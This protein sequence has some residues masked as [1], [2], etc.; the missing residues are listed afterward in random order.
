MMF[1][2]SSS[3][4]KRRRGF[5]LVL[6]LSFVV[7]LTVVVL[8]FLSN[9]LLQRTVAD[10]SANQTRADLFAKG[11]IDTIVGDLKQ[12]IVDGS[13]GGGTSWTNGASVFWAYSPATNSTVVPYRSGSDPTWTNLVKRSAYGSNAYPSGLGF[14]AAGP[15]RAANV[16][17]TTPSKNGRSY[18][19]ARWNKPLLLPATSV[20][21]FTPNTNSVK[22]FTPPD[23]ILVNRGGG[24]P[25]AWNTNLKPS[26]NSSD[27]NTVVGRYA[28]VVYNQGGLLDANVAGYPTT[29]LPGN[30]NDVARK[31]NESYADLTQVGLTAAQVD[32]LVNWRNFASLNGASTNYVSY[33]TRNPFGFQKTANTNLVSGM[34]DRRFISRQQ[35]IEFFNKKLGGGLP[36]Q[37]T[38]QYLGTFSPDKNAPSWEP[39][40]NASALGATN[41][42]AGI[43]I[44]TG[45]AIPNGYAY[46][47]N[48]GLASAINRR[49]PSVRVATSFTRADGTTAVPGEPLLNSRF[50]LGKLDW[51]RNDGTLPA[52]IT[53]ADVYNAFGLT[54]KSDGAWEYNHGTPGDGNR[55]M[56]LDE[57]ATAGR[58]PDFFEL[59]QAGILQGSLGLSSGD[60]AQ[61]NV[62]TAGGEFYRA[63]TID[64]KGGTIVRSDATGNLIYAQ[65]K[66][67]VLQI[68][69]NMIDQSDTDNFPTEIILDDEHFYGVENLPYLNALGDTALRP[70]PGG[71]VAPNDYQ[72]YVHRWLTISLWNPSQ[73][74]ATPSSSGPVNFRVYTD[75]GQ[76]YPEIHGTISQG[77]GYPPY[78]Q[79]KDFSTTPA[80]IA[81]NISDYPGAFSEPTTLDYDH[82][83]VA[84]VSDPNA[85]IST[86]L[87]WKRAGIY[88]GWSYAPE[89]IRKVPLCDPVKDQAPPQLLY[90]AANMVFIMPLTLRLQ[91]QDSTGVWHTYQELRGLVYTRDGAGDPYA[92]PNDPL[93]AQTAGTWNSTVASQF[94]RLSDD[95]EAWV[96]AFLDPRAPRLNLYG[97]R[98]NRLAQNALSNDTTADSAVGPHF[99]LS[100]GIWKNWVN[101]SS[102]NASYYT[103]RDF[104]RRVGDAAGWSGAD[105]Q[106]TNALPKRP[107]Q[108]NRAFQNAAELGYVFRDDPWKNL[109]LISTNSAD[110]ALLDLFTVGPIPVT[111]RSTPSISYGKIDLNGAS[112]LA[113]KALIVG[114]AR[115]YQLAAST[116]VNTTISAAD[117]QGIATDLVAKIKAAGPLPSVGALAAVF[118]QDTSTNSKYPGNKAQREAAIRA[119]TG[120][121]TTR[122]WN[123]LIDVVAQC[124]KYGPGATSLNDFT[125]DG[126]ARYWVHVAIDRYTGEV[127]AK[128]LEQ[129]SE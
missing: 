70:P 120:A 71:A 68:G 41:N 105:P 59:L 34:S 27:T 3:K 28:Y 8:A 38:L 97:R 54:R 84:Q 106:V 102:T 77:K 21:D 20:N 116:N 91:Y 79:G 10:S 25:T 48:A 122:T 107:M 31:G 66:F 111:K 93:W 108:L 110:G 121:S 67:Q 15:S 73:N 109:N 24:N 16:P 37:N 40:V 7:L 64:W 30:L 80:W 87:G 94:V 90:R 115:D 78:A 33:V 51:I 127:V 17:T 11:A 44:A 104:V 43:N 82:T 36:L 124:G 112:A 42:N 119:L 129:V 61:K 9:A 46:K 29:L 4:F 88:M 14:S 13:V 74:A 19:V 101:N 52:G 35:L 72:A 49:I 1:G 100:P 89:D 26:P 23:W 50:D 12:E 83:K 47:D 6:V 56:T 117:S 125:V 65:E 5:A 92:E 45:A 63:T 53:T 103:D 99:P 85:R 96:S 62:R 95:Q 86:A 75:Q 39:A 81:F 76:Q 118:P 98:N 32:A 2:L 58:E 55:I 114:T 57:V 18:S 60:P 128:L 113:L 22:A 126:E 123:F 69:A